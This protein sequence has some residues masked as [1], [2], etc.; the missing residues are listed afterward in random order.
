MKA[1]FEDSGVIYMIADWTN[2]DP[3]I[4]DFIE[5]HGRSGIPLYLVY[6]PVK[7][8]EPMILPQIL[9]RSTVLEALEVVTG[10]KP[11]VAGN[12]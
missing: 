1:A 10:E 3:D 5:G 12:Y 7:G 6:P 9:T 4:A 8:A 11:T 2:Y